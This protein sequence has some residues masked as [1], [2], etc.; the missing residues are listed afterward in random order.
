MVNN[1]EN[2]IGKLFSKPAEV[3]CTQCPLR[4]A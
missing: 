4:N 2:G 3:D 1:V